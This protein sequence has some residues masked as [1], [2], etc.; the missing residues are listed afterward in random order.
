MGLLYQYT[1]FKIKAFDNK[2]RK[3]QKQHDNKVTCVCETF[4]FVEFSKHHC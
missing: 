3:T 1:K 4:T 2:M